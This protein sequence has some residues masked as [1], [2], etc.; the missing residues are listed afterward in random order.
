MAHAAGRSDATSNEGSVEIEELNLSIVRQ[1]RTLP[2]PPAPAHALRP[3][4]R[5]Q[6]SYSASNYA[7]VLGADGP[8]SRRARAGPVALAQRFSGAA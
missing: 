8:T 3:R 5:A 2:T 7:A 1:V 4:P 6:A